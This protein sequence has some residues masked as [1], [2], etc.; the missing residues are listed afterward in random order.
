MPHGPAEGSSAM[1]AGKW[2]M[3]HP[4]NSPGSQENMRVENEN[5]NENSILQRHGFG[6][7]LDVR[8]C[9]RVWTDDENPICV[10]YICCMGWSG[11]NDYTSPIHST[12]HLILFALPLL[13]LERINSSW[14]PK[15]KL[16]VTVAVQLW[17]KVRLVIHGCFNPLPFEHPS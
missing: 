16:M 2:Q 11:S 8:D 12:W 5:E 3:P 13:S 1:N 7:W 17:P 4:P 14:F 10:V 6:G 15:S 9:T